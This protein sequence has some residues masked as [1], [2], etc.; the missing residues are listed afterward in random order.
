MKQVEVRGL[1]VISVGLMILKLCFRLL[2]K[3]MPCV[4]PQNASFLVAPVNSAVHR[5]TDISLRLD[6][7][8]EIFLETRNTF[9]ETK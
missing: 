1:V 2:D 9:Y 4:L 3:V 7:N 6:A 5:Q 8:P